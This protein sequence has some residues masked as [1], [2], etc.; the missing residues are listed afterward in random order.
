MHCI[1]LVT[2]RTR[3]PS[4]YGAKAR[5]PTYPPSTQH[6]QRM[7]P[8]EHMC[9]ISLDEDDYDV[10]FVDGVYVDLQVFLNVFLLISTA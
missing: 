3:A 1:S 10:G 7:G 9:R 4:C 5:G 8:E 2:H 6:V